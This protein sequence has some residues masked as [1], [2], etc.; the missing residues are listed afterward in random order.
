MQRGKMMNKEVIE[1]Y[2]YMK[3]LD[4]EIESILKEREIVRQKICELAPGIENSLREVEI[5]P[6]EEE[7]G[8][9]K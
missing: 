3:Q 1:L 7:Y 5:K 2:A 8:K 9:T 6:K 4:T